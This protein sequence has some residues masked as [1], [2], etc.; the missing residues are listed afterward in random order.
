MATFEMRAIPPAIPHHENNG[1]DNDKRKY[2]SC[3]CTPDGSAT[4]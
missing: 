4:P 2:H 1:D 3:N